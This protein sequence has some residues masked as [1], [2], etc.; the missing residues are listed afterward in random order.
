MPS[1][2]ET[3]LGSDV[4][5]VAALIPITETVIAE[6]SVGSYEAES[7]VTRVEITL[8]GPRVDITF[9]DY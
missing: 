5:A 9:L 1:V 7:R 8:S 4:I 2:I 6:E 3:G